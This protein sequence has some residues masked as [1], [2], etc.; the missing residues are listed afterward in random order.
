M[1]LTHRT[2]WLWLVGLIALIGLAGHPAQ[3]G[4][5]KRYIGAPVAA[6]E[7]DDSLVEQALAGLGNTLGGE[8]WPSAVAR[9]SAPEAAWSPH[10]QL[11]SALSS[12][13]E[14]PEAAQAAAPRAS[15]GSRTVRDL[16]AGLVAASVLLLGLMLIR[17]Q[18]QRQVANMMVRYAIAY[19]RAEARA[20]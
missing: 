7:P 12:T 18:R 2:R 8:R 4:P 5:M 15:A 13:P 10:A 17:R 11:V 1:G 9:R 3:A 20:N 16:V 6:P 19:R 14:T